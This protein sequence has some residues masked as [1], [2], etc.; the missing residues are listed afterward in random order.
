MHFGSEWQHSWPKYFCKRLL[1]YECLAKQ[2]LSYVS[3]LIWKYLKR[4][5]QSTQS[6]SNRK[7][8][9]EVSTIKISKQICYPFLKKLLDL[10]TQGCINNS[11]PRIHDD[12]FS[13]KKSMIQNQISNIPNVE[14]VVE[15]LKSPKLFAWNA[16]NPK[17][18]EEASLDTKTQILISQM[19]QS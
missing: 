15:A 3:E 8:S 6:N 12:I 16:T 14:E 4:S 10:D 18:S 19:S 7:E 2:E 9:N 11:C 17:E 1:R 13:W 5:F